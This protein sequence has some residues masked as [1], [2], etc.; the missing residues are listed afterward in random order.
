MLKRLWTNM[1]VSDLHRTIA[2]YC[3][4]LDFEHVMSVPKNSRD[5]LFNHDPERPLAYAMLKHGDVEMM[6][7]ETESL[8]ENVPAFDGVE[9]TGGTLTFY[10]EVEDVDLMAERVKKVCPL[11]R[12]L[13]DTFY[14]MRE[15]YVRDPDG[16]VLGFA[17]PVGEG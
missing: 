14:G 2:F 16:Y 17:Q 13:H 1:M 9:S 12:D 6:F 8:K 4:T 15:I 5:I 3:E 11:V 7:Q 10:F